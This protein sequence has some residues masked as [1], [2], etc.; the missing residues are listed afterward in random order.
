MADLQDFLAH[1]WTDE[2]PEG[3]VSC[4]SSLLG[5]F[6]ITQDGIVVAANQKFFDL[7]GYQREELYGMQAIDLITADEGAAMLSRLDEEDST[8]YPLKLLRKDQSIRYTMVSPTILSFQGNKYRLAEFIDLTAQHKVQVALEDSDRKYRSVF[9]QAAVGIARV[10]PDG[11]WLECNDKICNIVGYPRKEL[12][13]LTSQDITHPDDLEKDVALVGEI[14]AGK[15]NTYSME[16]RYFRKSGEIIWVNLTVSLVRDQ[17]DEPL[18]FISVIDDIDDKK[19]DQI[20]LK[21]VAG[22]DALTGLVNRHALDVTLKRE[23]DRALRYERDL[24]V[25]MLDIDNFKRVNDTL[26]H[27]CGDLVLAALASHCRTVLRTTDTA[28]RFGGEEFLLVLPETNQA[29]AMEIAERLRQLVESTA[30]NHDKGA[31]AITISL[32]VSSLP[33]HGESI[34]ELITSADD[35]MYKAKAGGRNQVVSADTCDG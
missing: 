2:G 1:V 15:R 11:S 25:V 30:M 17:R 9:N 8:R 19:R 29:S 23:I 10:A 16:K 12:L 6:L 31:I 14:L 24:S 27:D 26:G 22:H 21:Y 18:Y 33:K 4:F 3:I 35:A 20:Q 13:A 34:R 5:G 7:S 32:G 28:A